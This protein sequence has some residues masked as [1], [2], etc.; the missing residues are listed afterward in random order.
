MFTSPWQKLK[1][2]YGHSLF[3]TTLSSFLPSFLPFFTLPPS[4]LATQSLP[5]SWY[6]L[7]CVCQH[8]KIMMSLYG[9]ICL[10]MKSQFYFAANLSLNEIM[11]SLWCNFYKKNTQWNHT[12]IS[13]FFLH[14]HFHCLMCF[15]TTLYRGNTLSL[16]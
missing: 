14:L 11:I 5:Y 6:F 3:P 10:I 12:S 1:N 8:N 16:H 9:R 15:A 13:H 7:F 2:P 4:L